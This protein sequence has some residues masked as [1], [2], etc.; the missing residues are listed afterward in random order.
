MTRGGREEEEEEEDGD[1]DTT[2]HTKSV[3]VVNKCR[4]VERVIM[5]V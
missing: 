5:Y 2:Q 4:V 1:D 3:Q